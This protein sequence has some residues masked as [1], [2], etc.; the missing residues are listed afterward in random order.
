MT[1]NRRAL[2]EDVQAVVDHYDAIRTTTWPFQYSNEDFERL[3]RIRSELHSACQRIEEC[4]ADF[5]ENE[6]ERYEDLFA[7]V[8]DEGNYLNEDQRKA[9]VRDKQGATRVH[10]SPR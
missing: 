3:A 6:L 7:D 1:P 9:V 4:N 10:R 5:V 2:H 8:D